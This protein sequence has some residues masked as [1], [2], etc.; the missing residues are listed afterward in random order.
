M[1]FVTVIGTDQTPAKIIYLV[2]HLCRALRKKKSSQ[3]R[4]TADRLGQA[5]Y[6]AVMAEGTVIVEHSEQHLMGLVPQIPVGQALVAGL[7][8]AEPVSKLVIGW[9]GCKT[10]LIESVLAQAHKVGATVL[11]LSN[12]GDLEKTVALTRKLTHVTPIQKIARSS[13]NFQ[14]NKPF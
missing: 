13:R 9:F 4:V 5:A 1:S 6:E 12:K 3:F 8:G 10:D 7:T 2:E 11:D 14:G